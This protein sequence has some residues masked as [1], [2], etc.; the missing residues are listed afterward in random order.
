[1]STSK[2]KKDD[3]N[4][5]R[6][7]ALKKLGLLKDIDARKTLPESAKK[8]IR[9]NWKKYHRIASAPKS[10]YFVKDVSHYEVFEKKQLVN[11]GYAI[12][13]GKLYVDKQGAKSVS[14]KRELTKYG[15]KKSDQ[16]V[17][18]EIERKRNERKSEIEYV[19][20]NV[21]K[22]SLRDKFI[23]QYEAGKFKP[24]DYIGIKL[25]ENGAFR[26]IMYQ[27]IDDV[28][29]YAAFEFEPNDPRDNKEELQSQMRLVRLGV[30][31][32]AERAKDERSKTEIN[33]V[34]K[35]RAKARKKTAT[36]KL[37]TKK[38]K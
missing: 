33:R 3:P 2:T 29:K 5:A 19:T 38:R 31:H 35:A 7:A 1:M 4:K 20:T 28:Y 25:Y 16:I 12:I 18:I 9:D 14:I 10:E 8:K 15:K 27:S 37:V 36:K 22:L 23:Q 13:N 30:D 17:T 21:N 34:R 6:L 26:R 11:S 32:Y 24:G